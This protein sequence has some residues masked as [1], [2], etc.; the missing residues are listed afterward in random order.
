ML[1]IKEAKLF[2]E[3]GKLKAKIDASWSYCETEN[4]YYAYVS[5]KI[6]KGMYWHSGFIF[7]PNNP[8]KYED[9]VDVSR[10]S[11]GEPIVFTA[12]EDTKTESR[13]LFRKVYYYSGGQLIEEKPRPPPTTVSAKFMSG[14]VREFTTL[15]P[16]SS[17]T[18]ESMFD[19]E[20]CWELTAPMGTKLQFK[21]YMEGNGKRYYLGTTTTSTL[22]RHYY[23]EKFCQNSVAIRGG[24][25]QANL[26]ITSG[27]TVTFGTEMYYEG[28]L[29]ST[30]TVSI[31][32]VVSGTPPVE[33]D[34]VI[35]KVKLMDADT[36]F[37]TTTINPD[38]YYYFEAD[39]K[40]KGK[41]GD[42]FT[43]SFY[44]INKKREKVGIASVDYTLKKYCSDWCSE[45]V[46]YPYSV[47]GS[48]ILQNAGN[49]SDNF[50]LCCEALVWKDGTII[51]IV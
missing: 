16:L 18:P 49:P 35:E 2:I 20:I 51:K 3:G 38:K 34:V 31:P 47:A 39:V 28:R 40:L 37:E 44:V 1:Q 15:Q 43:F 4:C 41:G 14:E 8:S 7:C 11:E 27:T 29:L 10:L 50:Q 9:V 30:A 25:V 13:I 17:I 45:R 19:F 36:L 32:F 33:P 22:V 46:S 21:F 48:W 24:E 26:G 5:S 12:W 42:K 6:G 23:G